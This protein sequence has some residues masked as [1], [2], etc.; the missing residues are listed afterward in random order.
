MTMR[1]R[2][3]HFFPKSYVNNSRFFVKG[4]RYFTG[5]RKYKPPQ[6]WIVDILN[7]VVAFHEAYLCRKCQ[8]NLKLLEIG[9]CR[10]GLG[11]KFSIQSVNSQCLMNQS[12][13]STNKTNQV[14][15]VN[16]KSV[17]ASRMISTGHTG[18]SK[19]CSILGLLSPIVKS[20][21]SNMLN[22]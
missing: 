22:I 21:L 12:F 3:K 15:D 5:R 1:Q 2:G 14:F 8:R 18:L 13:Y 20:N 16:K 11:T 4:K 10:A 19:L 17:I 6:Y 9:S 7:I